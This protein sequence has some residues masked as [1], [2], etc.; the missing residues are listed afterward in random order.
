MEGL[1]E[2]YLSIRCVDVKTARGETINYLP[3]IKYNISSSA[4]SVQTAE[5][6]SADRHVSQLL[7]GNTRALSG[8]SAQHNTR[9]KI[10]R[11]EEIKNMVA[12]S[13][14]GCTI[15]GGSFNFETQYNH[16][17]ITPMRIFLLPLPCSLSVSLLS[18]KDLNSCRQ[19]ST[20]SSND[21]K[22]T[23]Y[24]PSFIML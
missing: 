8:H 14:A 1:N 3:S 6:I 17:L 22:V 5:K 20:I 19:D 16:F 21:N 12:V 23:D 13:S 15:Q 7:R 11:R 9:R 4:V 18:G 10:K 2:S 24:F